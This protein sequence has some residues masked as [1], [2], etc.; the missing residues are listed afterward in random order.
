M[1]TMQPKKSKLPLFTGIIAV[2][3]LAVWLLPLSNTMNFLAGKGEGKVTYCHRTSS[4]TN[5]F[6]VIRIATSAEPAHIAHGDMKVD[7]GFSKQQCEGSEPPICPNE[8][9]PCISPLCGTAGTVEC[10]LDGEICIGECEWT[11][12]N[13]VT[14]CNSPLVCP[15]SSSSS[16]MSSTASSVSSTATS[17]ASSVSSTASSMTSSNANSAPSSVASSVASSVNSSRSRDDGGE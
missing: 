16:S 5:P 17:A 1:D 10:N 7:K 6:V 3:A 11:D 9:T 2:A 14:D 4:E 15:L 13:G 8:G 12:E